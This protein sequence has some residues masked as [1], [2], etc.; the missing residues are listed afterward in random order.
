MLKAVQPEDHTALAA[1]QDCLDEINSLEPKISMVSTPAPPTMVF[2]EAEREARI[3]L[4]RAENDMAWEQFN[5]IKAHA[6]V[7]FDAR[8]A[9][10]WSESYA[11]L[12]SL[13]RQIEPSSG[14]A[15]VPPDPTSLRLYLM[16]VAGELRQR[17]RESGHEGLELKVSQTVAM[18]EGI[19]PEGL[20]ASGEMSTWYSKTFLPLKE[21]VEAADGTGRLAPTESQGSPSL[22]KTDSVDGRRD[23]SR[24]HCSVL[25]GKSRAEGYPKHTGLC[26]FGYRCEQGC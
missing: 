25:P 16:R 17:A 7:A 8:D 1:I 14:E 21:E 20:G 23:R 2:D 15:P 6:K 5:A 24:Y 10:A 4:G 22:R 26:P 12:V 18:L 9:A 19:D 11:M 13:M 3:W